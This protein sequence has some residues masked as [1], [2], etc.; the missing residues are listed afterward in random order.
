MTL[1]IFHSEISGREE[2]EELYENKFFIL[3]IL[4]V[5]HLLIFGKVFKA[6][7]LA[8]ISQILITLSK[9]HLDKSGIDT[10]DLQ[11]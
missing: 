8:N 1:S 7:Q 11:L 2:R 10:K 9:F 4:L 5:F 3:V 6:E